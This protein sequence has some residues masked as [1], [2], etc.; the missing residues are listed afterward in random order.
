MIKVYYQGIIESAMVVAFFYLAFQLFFN[1]EAS[2]RQNRLFL[3]LGVLL[4][5]FVPFLDF[6]APT[7]FIPEGFIELKTINV[8]TGDM[9]VEAN[10]ESFA[11]LHLLYLIYF[12]GVVFFLG[13]FLIQILNLFR[14]YK[15]A[16]IKKNSNIVF[17]YTG[18]RHPVFSFLNYVFIDT[19]LAH[20]K[21][22]DIIINHERVHVAQKHSIDLLLFELLAIVQWFSPFVWM[23]RKSIKQNHEF[24][25]DRGVLGNGFT[26]K[27]YQEVLLQNY[28]FLNYG[29]ANSFNHSLTFKR[30]IM[31]KKNN[32]KRKSVA[33]LLIVLPI[34][35]ISVYFISCSKGTDDV[36]RINYKKVELVEDETGKVTTVI[37]EEVK[38][39]EELMSTLN[40]EGEIFRRVEEM[41]EFPGG[42][43][44]LRK[45]LASEVKYPEQAKE[46]GL[47]GKVFVQFVVNSDGY[48]SST[49]IARGEHDVL[50]E[51]AMRVVRMLPKW[52]PGKQRGKAVS[53]YYTVPINFQLQ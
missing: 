20:S 26:L 5:L 41:P 2:F 11:K 46:M 16:R 25:A 30:L 19:E 12:I 22:L 51:E 45:F 50:N 21:D 43:L 36:D 49:E 39:D 35:I 23:Y 31:M 38:T 13:K 10:T 8:G 48:V 1:K 42:D 9:G 33:K 44:A 4:G 17:V 40:T 32:S 53:V 14:L 47:S 7:G 52:T 34:L 3:I 29:L 27:K 15:N 28:S 6:T 24:L 37:T 18:K